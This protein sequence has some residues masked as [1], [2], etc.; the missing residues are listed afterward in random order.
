MFAAVVTTVELDVVPVALRVMI[1]TVVEEVF[2]GY[3][4]LS[5]GFVVVHSLS[6]PV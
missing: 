4:A 6:H 2:H 1:S 3:Q 5:I